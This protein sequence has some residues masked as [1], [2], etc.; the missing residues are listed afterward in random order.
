MNFSPFSPVSTDDASDDQF[1]PRPRHKRTFTGFT[2][3]ELKA[4]DSVI[5]VQHR[6]LWKKFA[7]GEFKSKQEFQSEFVRHVETTLAR[8]LY[9]CDELAAYQAAS[10]AI[11]DRLVIAW[12][13]TQQKH[14]LRDP[15][16]IYYLSLE[17]L[18]GRALDN[19]L[20]NL[21]IKDAAAQGVSEFGFRVEDL[22]EQ[23]R[24]RKSVV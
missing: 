10:Q 19:A 23:E 5:P 12:N 17:F 22:I 7:I 18:M 9:N 24:D 2:P 14:T 11:R 8:S 3:R 15:K 13:K 1:V 6:N 20:L 4:I 16:R 21:D